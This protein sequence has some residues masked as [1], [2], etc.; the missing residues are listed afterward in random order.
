MHARERSCPKPADSE[1]VSREPRRRRA[2]IAKAIAA[3]RAMTPARVPAKVL[4]RA[5]A[6]GDDELPFTD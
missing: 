3:S 1:I 4:S 2:V 5:A 6:D